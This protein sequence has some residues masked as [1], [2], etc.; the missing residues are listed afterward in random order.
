MSIV[1]GSMLPVTSFETRDL[2]LVQ[3]IAET[4]GV[5]RAARLL[6]L[7]QSA[8]SHQL[9]ELETRLGLALFERRGRGVHM[10]H[11]GQRVLDLSREVLAPMARTESELRKGVA[12]PARSLRISTQ[13]QTAYYWLPRVL[14]ALERSH[15]DVV[16]RIVPEAT[17]DPIGALVEGNIDLALCITPPKQKQYVCAPLFDDEL[18]AVLPPAHALA[19]APFVDS[20]DLVNDTWFLPDVS[21]AMRDHV[22]RELF[23]NGRSYPRAIRVPLTEVIVEL[24]K[25]GQG[26]SVLAGWSVTVPAARREVVTVRLTR[27]GLFRRW[28]AAYA[29]NSRF[30]EA[31]GTLIDLVKD[32]GPPDPPPLA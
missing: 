29:R 5:T 25:A 7:S 12:K 17:H 32:R 13:C 23:P 11:A 1:D 28:R 14:G 15:P 3:A 6:H 8:V 4:G 16:L 9:K 2:R 19:R 26:I 10:T 24:V 21:S 27:R 30:K 22:R 20:A 18:V 31:I